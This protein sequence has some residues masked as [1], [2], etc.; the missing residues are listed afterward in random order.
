MIDALTY[1]LFVV[2]MIV[3][4]RF[5]MRDLPHAESAREASPRDPTSSHE[6]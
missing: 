4:L 3:C 1:I 2:A 6:R 5:V